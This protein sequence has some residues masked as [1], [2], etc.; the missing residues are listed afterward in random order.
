MRN[1]VRGV[2]PFRIDPSG[3]VIRL[4]CFAVGLPDRGDGIPDLHGLDGWG[5]V[6]EHL[7]VKWTGSREEGGR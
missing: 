3:H 4:G 5:S 2:A 7:M 1:V 6:V